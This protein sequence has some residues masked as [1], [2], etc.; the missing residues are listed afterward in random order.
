MNPFESA[1]F[2]LAQ[3]QSETG[4][5][6]TA[7]AVAAEK[8]NALEARILEKQTAL[9]VIQNRRMNGAEIDS[10]APQVALLTLDL[11][12]LAELAVSARTAHSA[13]VDAENQAQQ[14]ER[15]CKK[16]YDRAVAGQQAA[17]LEARLRELEEMLLN[18]IG[19]LDVLKKKTTGSL[20][21][22]GETLYRF[23]DRLK[24]FI[25]QGVLLAG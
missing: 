7:A 13:A 5:A 4:K 10:D 23:S 16:A 12:G 24:R 22:H 17:T 15:R 18:G 1:A 11:A 19:E 3:A 20:H 2:D 6:G 9:A 14:Q 21:V 8:L 25:A